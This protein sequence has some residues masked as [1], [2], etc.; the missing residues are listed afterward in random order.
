MSDYADLIPLAATALGVV[1]M[2][3]RLERPTNRR[4]G[5][6]VPR[7]WWARILAFTRGACGKNGGR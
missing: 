4:T 1:W 3:W 6:R 7:L 5:P 2:G